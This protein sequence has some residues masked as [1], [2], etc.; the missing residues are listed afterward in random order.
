MHKKLVRMM[1]LIAP[2]AAVQ[3]AQAVEVGGV[4]L[5]G[6]GFMTLGVGQMI[7]GTKHDVMDRH[8]PCFAADYAQGGVYDGRSG[9]QWQPDTKLGLQGTAKVTSDLSFTTQVVARGARNGAADLEWLYGSYRF[10][11]ALTLQVGRKRLPMFYY[12]D[13][14]DVGFALPWT[15]LPPQLYGWEAVNY[16]GINLTYRTQAGSWDLTGDLL[17]GGESYRNSG[18]DK[19]YYGKYNKTNVKWDAILGGVFAF[20]RDWFEGRMVYIQSHTRNRIMNG[21]FDDGYSAPDADWTNFARQRIY[22]ASANIDYEN[23]LLRSEVIYI[24]RPEATFK[25]HATIIGAGYRFGKWT[26]MITRSQYRG[27]ANIANGGDPLGQEGHVTMAYTLRYDLTT[28]SAIKLQYDDQRDK[29]GPNWTPNYGNA[30]LVT[31]TYDMV[32]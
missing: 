11:D 8:C 12:S 26:P 19:I 15:H 22:G 21:T 32:F 13:T 23:F 14:Q 30:K 5:T 9:L 20:S 6:S 17:Y 18:Y 28:S 10:N 4:E 29:G 3:P 31:L 1:A 16:N 24:D 25:D 2:M 27:Q 7:G